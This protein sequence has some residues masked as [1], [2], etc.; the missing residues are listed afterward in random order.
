MSENEDSYSDSSEVEAIQIHSMDTMPTTPPNLFLN[1]GAARP[2][3]PDYFVP[4]VDTYVGLDDTYDAPYDDLPGDVLSLINLSLEEFNYACG[5]H[6]MNV[7]YH[8]TNFYE[9]MAQLVWAWRQSSASQS[10]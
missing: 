7:T 9:L 3:S 4:L 10:P 6:F 5:E 8:R 1:L 2:A